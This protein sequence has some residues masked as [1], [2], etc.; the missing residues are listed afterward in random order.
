MWFS[1]VIFCL[2]GEGGKERSAGG[3]R[4]GGGKGMN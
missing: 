4:L 3:G 1:Y 2:E